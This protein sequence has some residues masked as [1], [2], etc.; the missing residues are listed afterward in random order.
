VSFAPRRPSL[1]IARLAR[2]VAPL[3]VALL[4]V[5]VAGCDRT[6]APPLVEVTELAPREVELGDRL[7]VHGSGFPQGRTGRVSLRGAIHRAGEAKSVAL[8]PGIE[9]EGTVVTPSMLEIVV[10]EPL[11]ERFCGRGD[12]ASHA[13]FR[14]DVDVSFASSTPGAPPLVGTLRGATLDVQ[15]ASVRASVAEARALEGGRVLS[16]LGIVVGAAT[17]RGLPIEQIAPGSQ[18][19]RAGIEVSDLLVAADGVHSLSIADVLAASSRSI[20]LTIRHGDTSPDEVKTLSLVGFA[21]ERIPTDYAPA[22]VIVGLALSV[23]FILLLPGPRA[24]GTLEQTLASRLRS[25]TP[26]A[27]AIALFGTGASLAASILV[28]AVALGFALTPYVVTPEADGVALFAASASLLVWSKL[29]SERG[30]WA[31]LGVLGRASLEALAMAAA[32][33]LT[34]LHVGAVELAEIVRVQGGSPWRWNAARQPACAVLVL[35]DLLCLVLLLRMRACGRGPGLK[36]GPQTGARPYAVVLERAGLLLASAL[37]AAVFF[38][39]WQ[40]PGWT[41]GRARG[42]SLL[43]AGGAAIFLLKTWAIFGA[44]LAASRVAP[45][46]S[47]AEQKRLV[48]RRVVPALALGAGLVAVSRRLV[49]GSVSLGVFGAVAVAVVVL[50]GLRLVTRIHAAVARPEPHASP[51]L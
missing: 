19:E 44:V 2:V 41:E 33:A 35:A 5:V 14:G 15:P 9:T 29:A 17:A 32:F 26:R 20:E 46:V 36:S 30:L 3:L 50:L 43:L 24:L 39:G 10:R 34:V 22:L 4:L 42:A 12:Q 6:V 23:L 18:A 8:G 49:P 13:T 21:T 28:S 16:F 31:T 48:L 1:A 37:A 45:P 11:T 27:L 51:F 38:G 7:E 25:T 47:P 40:L